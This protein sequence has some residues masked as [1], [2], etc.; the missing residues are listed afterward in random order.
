MPWPKVGLKL[1]IG[2]E[3]VTTSLRHR[4]LF[5]TDTFSTLLIYWGA[6]RPDAL[7]VSLRVPIEGTPG[8]LDLLNGERSSLAE[9]TRDRSSSEARGLAR[10][11]GR[12]MRPSRAIVDLLFAGH[13]PLAVEDGRSIPAGPA[14]A[15]SPGW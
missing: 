10:L 8:V 6:A 4:L 1:A 13:G 3:D 9:Y 14:R 11:T 15:A 2:Q 5:D 12:P 7:A